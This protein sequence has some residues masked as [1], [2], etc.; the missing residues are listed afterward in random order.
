MDALPTLL[1]REIEA[2]DK[3]V[4]N[5]AGAQREATRAEVAHREATEALAI[6]EELIKADII[7]NGL[8]GSNEQAR[9]ANLR[10]QLAVHP[11]LRRLRETTGG[12][13]SLRDAAAALLVV[14]DV[15]QKA[16]RAKVAALTALL[17]V[18]R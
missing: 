9:T 1:L 15:R 2:L 11:E 6:R 16:G 18:G 14:A 12:T 13:A 8:A 4:E 3:A 17:G 7:N 10:A 5:F